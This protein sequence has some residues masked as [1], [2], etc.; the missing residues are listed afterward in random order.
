MKKYEIMDLRMRCL[1]CAKESLFEGSGHEIISRAR[2]F[3]DFVNPFGE[4]IGLADGKE[5]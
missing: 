4:T 1:E 5:D 2:D 3:W